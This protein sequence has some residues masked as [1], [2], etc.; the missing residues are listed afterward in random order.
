MAVFQTRIKTVG[1]MQYDG[2]NA[3]QIAEFLSAGSSDVYEPE[4]IKRKPVGVW[5]VKS[6]GKVEWM[7]DDVLRHQY[8]LVAQADNESVSDDYR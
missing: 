4:M 3:N 8:Q 2:N 7:L 5:A 6:M 1:A